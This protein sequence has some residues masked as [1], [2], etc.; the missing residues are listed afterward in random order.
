MEVLRGAPYVLQAARP[1]TCTKENLLPLGLQVQIQVSVVHV[2]ACKYA[3]STIR[4][5]GCTPPNPHQRKPSSPGAPSSDTGQCSVCACVCVCVETPIRSS[6]CTPP[7]LHQIKPSSPG[8]P[9][10]DTGQCSVCA[11]VCVC[12]EHHTFFRLHAPKPAP[13]KTFFPWGSKFRYRSVWCVCVR[14]CMRGAPYVLQ[15]ARPKPAPKKTF[16][17]GAPS[18]DT[19]QCSA[20]ACV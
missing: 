10:S 11:C 20:R 8:A 3:W 16:F 7:N 9:S 14:V 19:G 18:S 15:A 2:R 13:K 6:G 12:V 4:S 5:S 1:Q 17:P